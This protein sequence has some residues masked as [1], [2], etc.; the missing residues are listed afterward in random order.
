MPP[1]S[2]S[3]RFAGALMT[4]SGLAANKLAGRVTRV[5]EILYTRCIGD[6]NFRRMV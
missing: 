3:A 1:V 6:E 5:Q 2:F 4:W